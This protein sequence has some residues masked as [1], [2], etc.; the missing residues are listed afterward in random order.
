RPQSRRQSIYDNQRYCICRFCSFLSLRYLAFKLKN[1]N[2]STLKKV[3]RRFVPN[4]LNMVW[5]EI[6]PLYVKLLERD[7]HSAADLEQWMLDRSELEAVI[8]E[9]AAWRYI[10]MTCNTADPA[11]V[12]AFQYFA[13]E[14]EPKIAPIN[15][16]LNEKLIHSTFL[17]EQDEQKYFVY[18]RGVKKSLEL[19][20]QENI[21]IQTEI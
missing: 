15:N 8:E 12:E 21:P 1:M 7:F 4:E 3:E 5:E 16:E 6:H 11:L 19:F 9:N 10:R 2:N 18:L 13:T 14:I 20:R 17:T